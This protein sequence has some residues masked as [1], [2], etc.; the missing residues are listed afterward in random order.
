MAELRLNSEIIGNFRNFEKCPIVLVFF[1]KLRFFSDLFL[2]ETDYF[3]NPKDAIS[4]W[5]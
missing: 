4:K 2:F 3:R 5:S 1:R